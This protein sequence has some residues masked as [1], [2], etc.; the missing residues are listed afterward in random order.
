MFRGAV[1]EPVPKT[2]A[3]LVR[4]PSLRWLAEVVVEELVTAVVK[5]LEV[6]TEWT[7]AAGVDVA[8]AAD[9]VETGAALTEPPERVIRPE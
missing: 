9:A 4:V 6:A 2:G 7:V 3:L 8:D 1:T 5:R